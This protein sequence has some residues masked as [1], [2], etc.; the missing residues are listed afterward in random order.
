[1]SESKR[2]C[3]LMLGLGLII[4][5]TLALSNARG[6]DQPT[7]VDGSGHFIKAIVE[8]SNRVSVLEARLC[9]VEQELETVRTLAQRDASTIVVG[10]DQTP[11][12]MLKELEG[13]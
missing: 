12:L 2:R 9:G 7:P 4:G 1:M 8:L 5:A 10:L 3:W 11:G 13:K 6:Q